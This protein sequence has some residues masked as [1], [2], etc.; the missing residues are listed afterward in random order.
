[1]YEIQ[2]TKSE[3]RST[4]HETNLNDQNSNGEGKKGLVNLGI[5]LKHEIGHKNILVGSAYRF[6]EDLR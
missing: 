2:N 4:K 3:T 1:M 6:K 5:Q